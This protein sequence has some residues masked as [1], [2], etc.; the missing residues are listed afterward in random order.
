MRIRALKEVEKASNQFDFISFDLF[1]TLV[2]RAHISLNAIHEASAYYFI[3][4]LARAGCTDTYTVEEAIVARAHFTTLLKGSFKRATEEPTI[5]SVFTSM[6]I[7][8]GV[9]PP[10]AAIIADQVSQYE[11]G[12]DCLSLQQVPGA[13][14]VLE[15]LTQAG[16][17]VFLLS[18][19]YYRKEYILKILERCAIGQYFSDVL[20][21]ATVKKTKQ[22]SNLYRELVRIHGIAPEKILH[23][24]DSRKSDVKMAKKAGLTAIYF[25]SGTHNVAESL[26]FGQQAPVLDKFSLQCAYFVLQVLQRAWALGLTKLYFLSRDATAL[27]QLL[28]SLRESAPILETFF[29]SIEIKEL[30]I[31]R[32]SATFLELSNDE[33]VL[34]VVLSRL[35]WIFGGKFTFERLQEYLVQAS[36]G[37]ISA[38][39]L[40]PLKDFEVGQDLKKEAAYIESEYASIGLQILTAARALGE[41]TYRY[42]LQEGVVGSGSVGIV[43]IGYTGTASRNIAHFLVNEAD[44]H[45]SSNSHIHLFLMASGLLLEKNL[46]RSIS[47]VSGEYVLNEIA[48]L[49]T[50]LR[51]NHCWFECF[52]KDYSKGPLL[53]YQKHDKQYV[54][55]F[56]SQRDALGPL[57][58]WLQNY[59]PTEVDVAR[60]LNSKHCELVAKEFIKEMAFPSQQTMEYVDTL[61]HGCGLL[62]DDER[63]VINRDLGF[64]NFTPGG[65]R[66]MIKQDYWIAGSIRA[67][68]FGNW[69]NIWVG[70]SVDV[71]RNIKVVYRELRLRAVK[72][73][74]FIIDR[75]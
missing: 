56:E 75:I 8:C 73:V 18:D 9:N 10:E 20:V 15:S 68:G 59:N 29:N 7:S 23:V 42:L 32:S 21:S 58:K 13:Q 36:N 50:I 57:A 64:L 25:N 5:E 45:V 41:I 40:L 47:H 33:Y 55:L 16:K 12:L 30:A 35:C 28:T 66:K 71:V 37:E 11:F 38:E 31:S 49:P 43:D 44:E 72:I 60:L 61:S 70:S 39:F 54:A 51:T 6:A 52:T 46:E 2:C 17:T 19:M 14:D 3:G 1:D 63:S 4:L 24:G 67:S 65:L 74:K 48:A 22:T 53:G 26:S 69:V 62:D 27:G 34:R